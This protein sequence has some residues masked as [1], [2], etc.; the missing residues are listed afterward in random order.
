MRK[1]R[2]CNCRAV[3]SQLTREIDSSF[4]SSS[5]PPS[6]FDIPRSTLDAS[7][8][9][10]LFT[11][12]YPLVESPHPSPVCS[13]NEVLVVEP[14]FLPRCLVVDDPSRRRCLWP[15][16]RRGHGVHRAHDQRSTRSLRRGRTGKGHDAV[17]FDFFLSLPIGRGECVLVSR[18]RLRI[19]FS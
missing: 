5:V 10:S 7:L 8:A 14:C 12:R 4:P 6:G 19:R 16:Y 1:G 13:I 15:G 3:S 9:P 18:C 2:R 17:G 11:G